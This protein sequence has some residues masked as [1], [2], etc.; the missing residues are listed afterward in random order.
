M[1][2][3]TIIVTVVGLTFFEII[4]SIDNA[5]INADVLNTMSQKARNW[6]LF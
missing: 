6:F 2:I 3:T 4:T 1:D 5:I